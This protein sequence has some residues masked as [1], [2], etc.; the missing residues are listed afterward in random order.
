MGPH[1]TSPGQEATNLSSAADVESPR[2]EKKKMCFGVG[3]PSS[4]VVNQAGDSSNRAGDFTTVGGDLANEAAVT[5]GVPFNPTSGDYIFVTLRS[6]SVFLA[7][8]LHPC[9][10]CQH[11]QFV[12]ET[13]YVTPAALL[14]SCFT[15]SFVAFCSQPVPFSLPFTHMRS[16]FLQP[17]P[18]KPQRQLSP[19][20]C[21]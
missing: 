20:F 6:L 8:L 12:N 1:V 13:L 7:F 18:C 19:S 3:Q 16:T 4:G 5:A 2:P 11:A 21:L 14:Q 10:A 17:S 9:L 15:C